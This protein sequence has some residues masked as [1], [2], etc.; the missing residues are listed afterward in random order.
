MTLPRTEVTNGMIAEYERFSDLIRSLSDDEWQQSTRCDGWRVADVAAHVAGILDD[1]VHFRLDDIGT[2]ESVIRQV[3]QRRSLTPAELADELENNRKLG[4]DIANSF[5]D[6]A[7]DGPSP[8]PGIST[9]GFGVEGLWYDTYVHIEDVLSAIG[10][11]PARTPESLRASVSHLAHL[12]TDQGYD[13]AT[14]ALDG[15]EE[16]PVSGGSSDNR[17]SGDPL[18]FVLVA[19]GR[20]TPASFG[21]DERI[22]VYRS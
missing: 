10:R 20:A 3:D 21:L 7:W 18:E 12:L 9:L 15:L 17:I 6:E 19:T 14:L 11:P 5:T 13:P 2:P 8:A 1:V 16:F 22:N 4:I